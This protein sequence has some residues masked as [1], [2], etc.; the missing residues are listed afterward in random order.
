LKKISAFLLVLLLSLSTLLAACGNNN[1]ATETQE[2]EPKEDF[3][4]EIQLGTGSTG[5]TYYPLGQEMANIWNDHVE[6]EGFKSSAVSTGAS[7]ENLANIGRGE[8]QL[9]LSVHT[10]AQNALNG[11][12][13][14]EGAPVKNFGFIGHIYPEVM[15]IVTLGSTGTESIA[16][17]KGKKVAIGPAGS[18]TQATAKK[19]LEAYGINDGDYEAFQEG[20]GD[21]KS[22][23]QDGVIDAAFGYLGSPASSIDELYAVT[24]DVKFLEITGKDV[25]KVEELTGD[26]AYE[27]PAGTYSWLEEPVQTISAYAILVASTDQISEDLGYELTKALFENNDAFTHQQASHITKENALK[28]SNGLELHPGA[29]KYFDEVGISQ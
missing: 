28:G 9:G 8:L 24:K 29:K 18:G 12:G 27:I 7:V 2:G 23:L 26:E 19:I 4:T 17:L 3:K 11:K 1:E 20:F 6:V 22:K 5:G 13:E 15:Q 10:T 16:D 14:F 21:A 25:K